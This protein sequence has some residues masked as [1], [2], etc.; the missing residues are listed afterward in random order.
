MPLVPIH[1][2]AAPETRAAWMLLFAALLIA[3]GCSAGGTSVSPTDAGTIP[4]QCEHYL[5]HYSKCMGQLGQPTSAV[6][7]RVAS[8]RESFARTTDPVALEAK[9]SSDLT[10]LRAACP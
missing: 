7:G 4:D 6:D 5:A 2:T 1:H 3:G 8:A 10:Q 9:C